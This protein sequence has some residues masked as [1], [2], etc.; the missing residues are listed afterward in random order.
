MSQE[1]R[2]GR[3]VFSLKVAGEFFPNQSQNLFDRRRFAVGEKAA[4]A[5][6]FVLS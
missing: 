3:K 4:T 5:S 6:H 1:V 2:L